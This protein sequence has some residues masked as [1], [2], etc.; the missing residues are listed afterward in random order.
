MMQATADNP[1]AGESA[2]TKP[3]VLASASPRRRELLQQIGVSF[4]VIVHDVDETRLP[5]ESAVDYV[6][7]LAQAKAAAVAAQERDGLGRPV[8]GADTIVVID[9]NVLGKPRDADDARRMLTLLSGC[10]HQVMSAVCVIQGQ[11]SA[12]SMSTTYVRFRPLTGQD[13]DAYWLSGEPAGKAGAYAVQGLAALFIEHLEGSYS[14]V[15]GLPL[16]ETAALLQQFSVPTALSAIA[17]TMPVR[18]R[19]GQE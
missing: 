16:Y 7:R 5:D 1:C 15:V 10:E 4:D 2:G 9:G 19:A 12:L 13:I 6:C 17:G 3:L 11:R 14:G 8:L 18:S